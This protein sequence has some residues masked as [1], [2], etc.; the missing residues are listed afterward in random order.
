MLRIFEN[1]CDVQLRIA[2][3]EPINED[4]LRWPTQFIDLGT[5]VLGS[6]EPRE[7]VPLSLGSKKIG[8]SGFN[9]SVLFFET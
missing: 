3:D 2:S 5:Q 4:C 8:V 6:M 7:S 9:V 1:S